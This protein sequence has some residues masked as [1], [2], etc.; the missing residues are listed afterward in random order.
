ML[1]AV[2]AATAC[3]PRWWRTSAGRS[4]RLDGR[5]L[6]LPGTLAAYYDDYLGREFA[7]QERWK[8]GYR[9]LLGTL[10]VARGS[11]LTARV[12]GGATG[13]SPSA[14]YDALTVLSQYLAGDWPDG[15]SALSESFR[16]FLVENRRRPVFPQEASEHLAAYLRQVRR[17]LAGGG[18]PGESPTGHY[19]LEHVL[20]ACSRRRPVLPG[21]PI[22][23]VTSGG[24]A[25]HN[26]TCASWKAKTMAT[27]IDR[28]LEDF[29]RLRSVDGM[30]EKLRLLQRVL[31]PGGH[32]L[33]GW[34]AK[35][36]R[37]CS[38]SSLH[39]RRQATWAT[40]SSPRRRSDGWRI[41]DAHNGRC[42]P[43]VQVGAQ[44]SL[45]LLRICISDAGFRADD[46]GDHAEW[47]RL[48]RRRRRWPRACS[49]TSATR[50]L[51]LW[52]VRPMP[53]RSPGLPPERGWWLARRWRRH[54]R[55]RSRMARPATR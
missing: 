52:T 48:R 49:R 20:P 39:L 18:V 1:R 17:W 13:L 22:A 42:R 3:T 40:A 9:Q 33:R 47:S 36:S 15:C 41:S 2:R 26:W 51:R 21:T 16:Q 37:S 12:L 7:G 38:P 19:A 43:A 6:Q 34:D 53:T 5:S 30:D 32:T 27:D 29:E 54:E 14:T 45:G 44:A 31:R 8:A 50:R 23:P 10:A 11:G 28:V 25:A 4:D 24:P 35:G 55:S 46:G